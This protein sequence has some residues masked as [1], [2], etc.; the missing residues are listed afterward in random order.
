LGEGC[1]EYLNS[2]SLGTRFLKQVSGAETCPQLTLQ[3][4]SALVSGLPTILGT[5]HKPV[6]GRRSFQRGGQHDALF[7]RCESSDMII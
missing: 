4:N 6:S 7:V 2:T 5:S 3:V 1:D